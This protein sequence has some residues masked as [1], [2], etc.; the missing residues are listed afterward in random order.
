MFGGISYRSVGVAEDVHAGGGFKVSICFGRIDL[1]WQLVCCELIAHT[2]MFYC[3]C[4]CC[5][6]RW[7]GK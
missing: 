7:K 6:Y 4:R 2:N 1:M 5:L 3:D